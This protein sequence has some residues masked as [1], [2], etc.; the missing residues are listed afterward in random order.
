MSSFIYVL[1]IRVD[2]CTLSDE[3][4]LKHRDS[5]K[6]IITDLI[7]DLLQ[8]EILNTESARNI[9]DILKLCNLSSVFLPNL[10]A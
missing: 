10:G 7:Q 5:E 1:Q 8:K 3:M 9:D 4:Q 2:G 6:C